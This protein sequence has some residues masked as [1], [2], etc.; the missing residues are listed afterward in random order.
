MMNYSQRNCS[1]DIKITHNCTR[2]AEHSFFF[3]ITTTI[4]ST[5]F[6]TIYAST[7]LSILSHSQKAKNR[8]ACESITHS[9]S[10]YDSYYPPTKTIAMA[11]PY[12]YVALKWI[13]SL[14]H[15][16]N[17]AALLTKNYIQQTTI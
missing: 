5:E 1:P 6:Y 8:T 15:R 2:N 16:H 17:N 14:H 13:R 3:F 12:Q 11:K 4:K 7:Y 10:I 9:L